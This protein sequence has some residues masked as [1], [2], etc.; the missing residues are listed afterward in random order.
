[1]AT[2]KTPKYAS[3]NEVSNLNPKTNKRSAARRPDT[4]PY[5]CSNKKQGLSFNI[6][7]K[8]PWTEKQLDFFDLVADK[9]C[10]VIFISGPAGV[11]KTL[12]SVYTSLLL[13]KEKKVS[14]IVYVRT[15]IE[16]AS[17]S[18][19]ALPGTL[20][21]KLSVYIEPI[22]DKLEEIIGKENS[23]NLL[24][25]G[26][27]TARPINYLRG[28][29]F[30]S[31]AIIFDEAQN[32]TMSEMTTFLTR[33]GEFSKIFICGDPSQADIRDSSFEKTLRLF[34]N[35]EAEDNGIFIFEFDE[36][37]ILRSEI[38]KFIVKRLKQA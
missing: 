30:S 31:K 27:V 25:R 17:K 3:I 6:D 37:D 35:I 34:D 11:S 10:K 32:S 12:I 24:E 15:A 19:G 22:L 21:E 38:L 28:C 2:K 14:E 13:L 8:I 26:L 9:E 1:M 5:V 18:L 36:E 33:I 20:D 23:K 16:S 29:Q 4:S 7:C